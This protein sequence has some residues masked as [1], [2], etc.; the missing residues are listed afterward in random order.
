MT[1]LHI[2]QPKTFF[3]GQVRMHGAHTWETVTG[4]CQSAESAMAKAALAMKPTDFRARVLMLDH[5][6]WYP[7]RVVMECKR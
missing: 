6:G 3:L 1:F 7:P 2:H 4:R 5:E